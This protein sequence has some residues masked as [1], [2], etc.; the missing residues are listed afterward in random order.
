M[1][2][3][4]LSAGVE[5]EDRGDM[6]LIRKAGDPGTVLAVTRSAWAALLD[7]IREGRTPAA[8]P[9]S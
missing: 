7:S 5:A 8:D 3:A 4:R 9:D 6:I 1:S 2:Q